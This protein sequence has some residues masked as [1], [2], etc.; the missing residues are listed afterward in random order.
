MI[1]KFDSE[2][3]MEQ[4]QL[5]GAKR[6]KRVYLESLLLLLLGPTESLISE[7]QRPRILQNR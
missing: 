6:Q 7:R 4:S 5:R 2:K 3:S 1:S